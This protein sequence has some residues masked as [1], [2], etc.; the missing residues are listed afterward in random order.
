MTLNLRLNMISHVIVLLY[1]IYVSFKHIISV[2]DKII[3]KLFAYLAFISAIWL[4]VHRET[5]LPFLGYCAIPPSIF[6]DKLM[7]PDG[8][9]EVV[10]DI[11]AKEGTRVIYW[12]AQSNKKIQSNPQLAYGDY[13]NAGITTISNGQAKIRINCPSQYKVGLGYTLKRHIHYRTIFDNGLVS[14]V[15]TKYVSC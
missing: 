13:S 6:K 14:P 11:D 3:K 7:P 8:N 12:G 15:Q 9:I 1:T 5:Y 2:N 10:L 4:L